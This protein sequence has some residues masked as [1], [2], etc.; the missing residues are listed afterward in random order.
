MQI[1]KRHPQRFYGT[2]IAQPS[3]KGRGKLAN[4]SLLIL[5]GFDQGIHR[6]NAN[7][8]NGCQKIT[9]LVFAFIPPKG[10]VQCF[11]EIGQRGRMPC[12]SQSFCRCLPDLDLRVI[13]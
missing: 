1:I 10:I 9:G 8:F 6:G 13:Q 4:G 3:E 2:R 12:I 11:H 5:Q 7:L